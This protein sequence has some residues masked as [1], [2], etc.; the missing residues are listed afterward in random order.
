MIDQT[1][2]GVDAADL[3]AFLK[4]HP[5]LRSEYAILSQISTESPRGMVLVAA[6]ELDRLLLDLLKAIL[7][8]GAGQTALLSDGNAPL[9]TFSSKIAAAH[10]LNLIS[11]QEFRELG[12]I[13]R[14][15]N[16]FAHVANISFE[17]ETVRSRVRELSQFRADDDATESFE[18]SVIKLTIEL[19]AT[20]RGIKMI[21]TLPQP[22]RQYEQR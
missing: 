17:S 6:A 13:R 9:A 21:D 22:Q 5:E 10:A 7:R 14:I 12:I 18:A 8:P 2:L 20:I 4:E 11:D 16:D 19:L 1:E 3:E 15:R